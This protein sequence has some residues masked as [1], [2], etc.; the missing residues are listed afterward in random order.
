MVLFDGS[1]PEETIRNEHQRIEQFVKDNADLDE[2]VEW[3]KRTM[4]F[5]IKGKKSG[6]Y[7]LYH[8]TGE[9]DMPAKLER[10]FKMNTSILRHLTVVRNP[11]ARTF[12]DLARER[13]AAAEEEGG[14]EEASGS[15]RPAGGEDVHS[16]KEGERNA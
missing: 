14:D 9:G 12:V 1:L 10:S 4:A 7:Y 16:S 3:G 15:R 5:E 2:T 11:A 8:Y 13:A 6:V